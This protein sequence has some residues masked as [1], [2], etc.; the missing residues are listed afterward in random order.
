M[1][2]DSIVTQGVFFLCVNLSRQ[3]GFWQ[4]SDAPCYIFMSGDLQSS[5]KLL[6]FNTLWHLDES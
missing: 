1:F 2:S 4:D 3:D 5:A 6:L